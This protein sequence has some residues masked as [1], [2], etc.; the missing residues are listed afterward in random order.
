M[1]TIEIEISGAASEIVVGSLSKEKLNRIHKVM[2]ENDL[3]DEGEY[4]YRSFYYDS[5]LV[6]KAEVSQW[7]D[8]DQLLHQHGSYAYGYITVQNFETKEELYS[9]ELIDLFENDK[10]GPEKNHFTKEDLGKDEVML[11]AMT[12]EAGTPFCGRIEVEDD[13]V[14]DVKLLSFSRISAKIGDR[15][16]CEIIEYVMYNDEEVDNDYYETSGKDFEL[17][18]IEEW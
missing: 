4:D 16:M 17:E 12:S 1:K 6:S 11:Y 18:I 13:H 15:E 2:K 5:S 14:F 9:G 8:T 7:H 3:E 10:Y